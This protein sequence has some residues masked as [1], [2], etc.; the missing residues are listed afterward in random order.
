MF[1][2]NKFRSRWLAVDVKTNIDSDK[3][4][5]TEMIDIMM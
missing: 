1:T 2:F 3:V 4:R 5:Q